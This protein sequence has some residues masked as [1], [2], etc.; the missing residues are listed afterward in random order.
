MFA[1]LPGIGVGTLFYVLTALWM[2]IPE[3]VRLVRGRSS[4]ARWRL[5]AVQFVFAL[6]IIASIAVAERVLR[7]ML[8]AQSP[9]SVNPARLIN[10]GFSLM[11]PE[12]ILAAPITASFILLGG[13]LLVVQTLRLFVADEAGNL[14]AADPQTA[15][16]R[17]MSAERRGP[18]A[19]ASR[20]LVAGRQVRHPTMAEAR[21]AEDDRQLAAEMQ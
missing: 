18:L 14:P 19:S 3:L 9:A 8:G 11:S 13:V 16:K 17:A 6:S 2:P 1:G 15:L 5:I 10:R 12:S 20:P 7:W 21:V 4:A